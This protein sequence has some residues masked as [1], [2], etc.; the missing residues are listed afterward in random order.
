MKKL[1]LVILILSSFVGIGIAS[2][3]VVVHYNSTS[4]E[5][6]V[7]VSDEWLTTNELASINQIEVLK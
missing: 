7:E 6:E 2:W 5:A 3:Q 1:L 4:V